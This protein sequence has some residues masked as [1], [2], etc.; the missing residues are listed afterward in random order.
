MPQISSLLQPGSSTRTLLTRLIE[1][2][3]VFE[4]FTESEL[5]E[6]LNGAEKRVV[7]AGHEILREGDSGRF[8]YVLIEGEASVTK[9][10]VDD[11]VAH[12]LGTL[13]SG[14]CFGEMALVDPALRSATIE[15]LTECVMIRFQE[16]DCWNNPQIGS[17]IYRNIARVLARR[18]RELQDAVTRCDLA[19]ESRSCAKALNP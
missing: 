15:A 3:P 14:D 1:N 18:L 16:S 19:N 7:K 9:L 8:M 4:G 5:L 11:L 10:G 12:G 17:K 6:L 13:H 2:V